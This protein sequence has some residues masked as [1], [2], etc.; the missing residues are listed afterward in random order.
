MKSAIT[1]KKMIFLVIAIT[2]SVII[3]AANM[4]SILK[5]M[6]EMVDLLDIKNRVKTEGSANTHLYYL[7]SISA[8]TMKNDFISNLF[9]YAQDVQVIHSLFL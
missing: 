8:I 2:A 6:L 5:N 1:K 4:D 7:T 3:I 9:G